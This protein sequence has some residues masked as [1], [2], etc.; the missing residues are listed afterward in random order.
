VKRTYMTILL[1]HVGFLPMTPCRRFF[2]DTQSST[3]LSYL[4]SRIDLLIRLR[5]MAFLLPYCLPCTNPSNQVFLPSYV[6]FSFLASLSSSFLS[7]VLIAAMRLAGDS[8]FPL[9]T[10][11]RIWLSLFASLATLLL[12]EKSS[13][14]SWKKIIKAFARWKVTD[15]IFYLL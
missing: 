8:L 6:S 5:L 1:H 2:H 11:R 10:L 7:S 14:D 4:T 15:G 9:T 12:W 3:F 13:I